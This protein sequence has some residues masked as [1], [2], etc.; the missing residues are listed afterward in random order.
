MSKTHSK[1]GKPA[2]N[3]G[4]DG[5]EPT[6]RSGVEVRPV[7][8]PTTFSESSP[9]EIVLNNWATAE[10]AASEIILKVQPTSVSEDRR[11]DV[12]DYVQRLIRNFLGVEV[13]PYGSVP[14]KTYL[15]DGDIDLTAF[16]VA[17]VEDSLAEDMKFV[18]EN[19]E[20]ND[21]EFVVKDVQLIRAEVKIVKCI[22]Q[23]IV[24]DISSNQIG[25]L[26]TLCFLEKVDRFIGKN[27]LFKRSIILIKAWCYY[28][29]R[30]LGAHHGL[31]STYALET[32]VLYI[33]HLY[34]SILDGPLSVLYKF[35]D[36]FSKF[37][38]ETH[39]VSLN[40]P[41][42]LSS[43]PTVVVEMP[44]DSNGDVLLTSDF[45]GSCV[46]MFSVP[47]RV[48]DNN[49][50]GF[51]PKH[52]N[53]VDPLKENNNL[54]RSV[55]KGNFYRVR[56]AFTYGAR[57][58]RRILLQS[59]NCVANELHKFF[60]NTTA[61]HGGNHRPDVQDLDQILTCNGSISPT[62]EENEEYTLATRDSRPIS[63]KLD[64][65]SH[66]FLGDANDLATTGLGGLKISYV[67]SK[68]QP[69]VLNESVDIVG[70][71]P[72]FAPHEFFVNSKSK[73]NLKD[74]NLYQDKL[75]PKQL[76]SS[77]DLKHE[78]PESLNS[79]IDLAGDYDCHFQ[80]LQYSRRCYEYALGWQNGFPNRHHN[81]FHPIPPL[82]AMQ[83]LPMP[84]VA[85]RLEDI[86]KPRGTG[87]YFPNM[88]QIPPSYRPP[89][90]MG[91]N[92][93]SSSSHYRNG[94]NMIFTE[95]QE[96]P[97]RPQIPV[98]KLPIVGNG[99]HH[100]KVNGL[101]IQPE[102]VVE[103]GMVGEKSRQEKPVS[104][105]PRTLSESEPTLSREKDRISLRSSSYRLKDE[106]DFPPLSV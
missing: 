60:S 98:D 76:S 73:S 28:E 53:I 36:Y 16:G 3:H 32:L 29:S 105:S 52:L 30:I 79:L 74:E 40:G 101:I 102:G 42:R 48:G 11:R 17:N 19:E 26:S 31:I 63:G 64:A 25:G 7:A 45:L 12:I 57:K 90:M 78:T 65:S 6:D 49:L 87:T 61:R 88:N 51:Q 20:N 38:W 99:Y 41:I 43:L 85:Y 23:N 9:T 35:L 95:F 70:K 72:F 94:G 67:P 91:R 27:H 68:H 81:G 82:Y 75:A 71:R 14:L 92:K 46:E 89:A 103:Y 59:E 21:S 22:V 69:P 47:L 56:S 5:T 104:S 8:T 66:R 24:V 80:C 15:P 50:R 83:P 62:Y 100:P 18:L 54:G 77:R 106:D 37:D 86:P 13:L 93:A 84:N 4:S 1:S 44:E 34:H 58:L 33:F 97:S 2:S 39:C 55:S 96:P 10:E